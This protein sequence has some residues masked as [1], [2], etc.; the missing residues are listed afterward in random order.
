MK[1]RGKIILLVTGLIVLLTFTGLFNFSKFSKITHQLSDIARQNIILSNKVVELNLHHLDHTELFKKVVEKGILLKSKQIDVAEYNTAKVQYAAV[2]SRFDQDIKSQEKI[3]RDPHD[4]LFLNT[5]EKN[6]IHRNLD[7]IIILHDICQPR[8]LQVFSYLECGN[9]NSALPLA[10]TFYD[11]EKKIN[12]QLS[13]LLSSYNHYSEIAIRQSGL[14]QKK[15][16][17]ELLLI[18]FIIA[19]VGIL[20]AFILAQG[21]LSSLTKAVWFAHEV[22]MG[23]RNLSFN[24]IPNDEIGD[25]LHTLKT[26]LKSLNESEQIIL[27]EKKKSDDLLLNILPE[28]VAEEL[29]NKGSA[30]AKLFDDVT[31]LFTD[32][33]GFTTVAERLTPQQLVNELHACFKGF[34]EIMGKYNIEKIKTVGDAYLAVSGLPIANPKHAEN[35]VYAAIE[36]SAFMKNRK[37]TLGDQTFDIRIGLHSGNVVAGIVGVK[38]FAYDIWGD[39]VNTAARMEQNSEA[40]KI[41]ISEST[42]QLVKDK[43]TCTYRGEINAKNKGALGMYFVESH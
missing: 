2:C 29:K 42:Y 16:L 26:M 33:K 35:M 9:L 38:K 7:S 17:W 34:D 41:N 13:D 22:E 6:T 10:D 1:I 21:I 28:E 36:I 31:V 15:I 20:G 12:G 18:I 11:N 8:S 24:N 14:S 4:F 25:L 32:F 3:M 5:V 37:Q 23:N 39:T 43:F 19:G 30:D 40:G 27:N